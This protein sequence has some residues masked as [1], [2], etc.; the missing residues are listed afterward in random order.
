[1]NQFLR[2]DFVY[3][4]IFH[5]YLWQNNCSF[6]IEKYSQFVLSFMGVSDFKIFLFE[7][8]KIKYR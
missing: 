4:D 7:N 5:Q 8:I 3:C 2:G 1:M 6:L